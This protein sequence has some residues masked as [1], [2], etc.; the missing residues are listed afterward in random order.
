[1]W[2]LSVEAAPR[3]SRMQNKES[4]IGIRRAS[5]K[6]RYQN[7]QSIM[8]IPEH[9]TELSIR[10]FEA[11]D[12]SG[13]GKETL[14]ERRRTYLRR[15]QIEKI[16]Q[17][18]QGKN[19]ECFHFGSQSEG[20]TT[21]GLQSDIDFLISNNIINIMT[22]WED[23]KA[24]ILN[25]LMLH[26]NTTPP[27][28]YLLQVI[29]DYTPEPVTSLTHDTFVRKDSGQILFSAERWKNYIAYKARDQGE[30]A[31]NGPSVSWMPNWDIVNACHVRKPLPEIQHWIDRC[32][33]K[34]WPPVQLL[35][36]ARIAPCFL[37]PAG[38]PDSDFKSE[39]WRLS[40]NLIERMLM[41]S[42]NMTQLKCYIILKQ[43]KKSLIAKILG[44]SFTSFHCKTIMFYTIER[45]HHS[46]WCEQNLMFLLWLCLHVLRRWLRLG[47]LPHYIIEGVNLFDG[48]L[49]KLLQKRI[50]VYLDSFIRNNLQSVFYIGIDNK[51]CRFQA[52][53]MRYIV[54]AGELRGVRLRNSIRLLLK[55][56]CLGTFIGILTRYL[57][58]HSISH[59]IFDQHV[60][61]VIRNAFENS[62]N[63][64]SKT[65]AL[66]CIKLLYAL[67]ISVQSSYYL[68]LRHVLDSEHI[69]RV[70]YSFHVDV[71]S[72]RLKFA[73]LL[74]CSGHLQA[75][76]R[77]LE[78]VKRRYHSTVKT[79]CDCRRL[80]GDR[81]LQVF[82]DMLSGNKEVGFIESPFAF[83]VRFSRQ[84]SYCAP[85]I[86]L[87][88]MN[89]NTTEEEVAQRDRVDK[90]WMDWAEVDARPF[91]HYLQYLTYGGLGVRDNQLR[92][93]RDLKSC[94][95]DMSVRNQLKLY[96][97]ETALNLL[98][99]CC[100]MEGDYR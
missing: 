82:A 15:E 7:L 91:L 56:E 32:R 100:E 90:R 46:M 8:Q 95:Y 87:F 31:K 26:D 16:T 89:R 19:C 23:W 69:R 40:P 43:I 74:Y 94:M 73:S 22:V 36:A 57:H 88:E 97:I 45:T 20:T 21:P 68:R 33:G 98:G 99:H 80:V 30:A 35:E 38:H 34:H 65:A 84:E 93:L 25:L 29:Q 85:F 42:F 67:H 77:V 59:I 66:E 83:C 47:R 6:K 53:S 86:L 49:S 72:S 28:Q 58:E 13:A 5:N 37:V 24:G 60:K 96:H 27:Q 1:M 44:D 71:A 62:T 51:G 81:D 3:E 75:A 76:V 11:V 18:L 92:A 12:D 55:F 39:E 52:C 79:V 14:L 2:T 4:D 78:D 10:M 70:Q 63:V 48:K 54:Q 9:F 50:L 61:G 41:F 64:I 17:Q